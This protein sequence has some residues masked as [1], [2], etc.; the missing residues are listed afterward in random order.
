MTAARDR[1]HPGKQSARTRRSIG[2]LAAW[3]A[4]A[5]VLG[6]MVPLFLCMP[7]WIDTALFDMCAREVLRGEQPYRDFF[8]HG[9][10]GMILA[11]SFV[12]SIVGWSSVGLRA[13]DLAI[14]TLIGVL[15]GWRFLQAS[16][17]AWRRVLLLTL[18]YLFYFSVGEWSHCQSDL[19]MLLPAL[20]AL[21]LHLRM[22][23]WSRPMAGRAVL[24]GVAWGLAF[25]IKPFVVVPA[26]CVFATDLGR[27]RQSDRRAILTELAGVLFGGLMVG[28]AVVA[29]LRWTGN[30]PFFY[31]ATFAGWNQ[32]YFLGAE[33][34][35]YRSEHLLTWFWP[36]TL[37]HLLAVPVAGWLV[38]LNFL[39]RRSTDE[40]APTSPF[41]PEGGQGR[42]RGAIEPAFVAFY[43]GW[44]FQATY[45]QHQLAYQMVPAV[46][47]SL[48]LLMGA[49]VTL[50]R[51][52][53]WSLRH[54]AGWCAAGFL[55]WCL[56]YHPLLA[57]ARMRVWTKCW[58][59]GSSAEIRNALTV[60]TDPSAPDWVRLA[61]V[62]TFLRS[63]RLR[64][65]Q[66]TCY[67]PSTVHVYRDLDTLP[68]TRFILLMPAMSMFARHRAEIGEEVRRSPERYILSDLVLLGI[69]REA[70]DRGTS[71][72]VSDLPPPGPDAP[73]DFAQRYPYIWPGIF[74]AGRYIVHDKSA[75]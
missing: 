15:C 39:G 13:A 35:V 69:S 75:G 5:G 14:L 66:L 20:L 58:S 59:Q 19:W 30:W 8:L 50:L 67:A 24:E 4:L 28:S 49:R 72:S 38:A 70:A 3:L 23:P 73:P 33:G 56:L 7:P 64:D 26:L 57:P 10:P 18:I 22:L 27:Y 11:Y 16:A 17:A 21:A 74:R 29:W 31:E 37:L 34:P 32:D 12:R 71:L 60:E 41:H 43:L 36:W 62:E 54:A 48:T 68:S 40:A 47:L 53:H 9:P 6:A 63:R 1:A 44:L 61:Q 52:R 55:G 65:H 42:V 2:G 25:L 51:Q 46:I 45:L